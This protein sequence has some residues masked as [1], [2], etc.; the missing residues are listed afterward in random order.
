MNSALSP[1]LR[2]LKETPNTLW[3]LVITTEREPID[4]EDGK[5]GCTFGCFL[6]THALWT[7]THFVFFVAEVA[8]LVKASRRR[9][10]VFLHEK[11]VL[12]RRR[13]LVGRSN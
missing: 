13:G 10:V 9:P 6:S 1:L 8:P 12:S 2:S 5:R 7:L 3:W 4:D 11:A